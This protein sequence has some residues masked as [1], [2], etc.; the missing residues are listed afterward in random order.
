MGATECKPAGAAAAHLTARVGEG[1]VEGSEGECK[2][3]LGRGGLCGG[4]G[5]LCGGGLGGGEGGLGGGGGR[6]QT[7]TLLLL[8]SAT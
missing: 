2:R 1:E 5:G 6:D 7:A 3:G 4:E 8:V